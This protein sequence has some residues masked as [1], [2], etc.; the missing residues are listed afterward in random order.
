MAG[1]DELRAR[2]PARAARLTAMIFLTL[3]AMFGLLTLVGIHGTAA[4]L[5]VGACCAVAVNIYGMWVAQRM[6]R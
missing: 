5:W 3:F 1:F 4:K 6:K 2:W